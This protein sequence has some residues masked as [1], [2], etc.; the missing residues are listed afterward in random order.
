MK[1]APPSISELSEYYQSYFHYLPET[2]LMEAMQR[3]TK[4]SDKFYSEITESQAGYS[5]ADGK[6]Q[7]KEVVGHICD[8]ER[9][10]VYRALRIARKDKTPI[11]AFDE[12]FYTENSFYSSRSFS[13]IYEEWKSIRAASLSFFQNLD[14]SSYGNVGTANKTPVSVKAILYFIIVHERHHQRIIRERYLNVEKSS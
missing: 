13:S 6:W 1:I 9:I 8:T 5:Y 10:M 7:L 11:E 14:L 2:D 12:N 3:L 4:E